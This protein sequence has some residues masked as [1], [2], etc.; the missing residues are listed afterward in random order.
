MG[1]TVGHEPYPST[2]PVAPS[3]TARRR[4]R[5]PRRAV[6][7]VLVL[8][9]VGTV[10]FVGWATFLYEPQRRV[11]SLIGSDLAA[12]AELP[13]PFD[14][15]ATEARP[16]GPA[17]WP[18]EVQGRPPGFGVDGDP[19]PFFADGL[20]PGWYLWS[21][22]RGWHLWAVG[23]VE[24]SVVITTNGSF[25]ADTTGGPA[26]LTLEDERLE[27]SRGSATQPVV[28]VDFNPGFFAKELTVTV[29]GDAPLRTGYWQTEATSPLTLRFERPG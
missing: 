16:D 6:G 7:A 22:F 20:A 28:G 9:G 11:G 21:D 25:L 18:D 15:P 2:A 12:V 8:V 17:A 10:A 3:R 23:D 27:L 26:S 29:N 5:F 4:R 13:S 24:G 14:P 19:P 1:E